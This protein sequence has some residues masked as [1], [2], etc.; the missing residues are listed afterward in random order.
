MGGRGV[1]DKETRQ[2]ERAQTKGINGDRRQEDGDD[3]EV[4]KEWR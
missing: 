1:S 2:I 4:G 3:V